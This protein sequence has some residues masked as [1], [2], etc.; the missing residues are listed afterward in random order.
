MMRWSIQPYH[1]WAQPDEEF[2]A[3]LT[4]EAARNAIATADA[5][6]RSRFENRKV[7]LSE[8]TGVKIRMKLDKYRGIIPAFYAL[9]RQGRRGK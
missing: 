6:T 1:A 2:K 5:C 4:G 3:L 7:K 9:L 8:I